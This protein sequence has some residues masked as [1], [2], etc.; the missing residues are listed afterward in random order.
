[1]LSIAGCAIASLLDTFTPLLEAWAVANGPRAAQRVSVVS[2]AADGTL[3]VVF[4][5]ATIMFLVWVGRA[6]AKLSVLYEGPAERSA[7]REDRLGLVVWFVPVTNLILPAVQV[8]DL[9]MKSVGRSR[10]RR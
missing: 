7:R 3:A 1:M 5:L 8:A 6:R 9:A 10:P 4:G 2:S